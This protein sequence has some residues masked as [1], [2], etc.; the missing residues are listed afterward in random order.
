VKAVSFRGFAVRM[1]EARDD[2]DLELARSASAP[3]DA[4]LAPAR[5]ERVRV[6]IHY[7]PV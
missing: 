1:G 5:I 6:E 4:D 7:C 2:A 3:A